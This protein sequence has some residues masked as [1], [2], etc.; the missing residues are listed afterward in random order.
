M[1]L[2]ALLPENN[3]RTLVILELEQK[4]KVFESVNID[5]TSLKM[6]SEWVKW[7]DQVPA[8]LNRAIKSLKVGQLLLTEENLSSFSR[9]PLATAQKSRFQKYL[10]SLKSKE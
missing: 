9:L 3:L 6:L 2:Q 8:T 7:V 1:G 4:I 5:S 10:K